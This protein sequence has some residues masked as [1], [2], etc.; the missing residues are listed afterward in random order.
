[1]N[2]DL[3]VLDLRRLVFRPQQLSEIGAIAEDLAP[4]IIPTLD[5]TLG[6]WFGESDAGAASDVTTYAS[7]PGDLSST[8]ES[9]P[10]SDVMANPEP[11]PVLQDLQ[12]VSAPDLSGAYVP[13]VAI[14][15]PSNFSPA[16]T[17]SPTLEAIEPT[18]S[19]I[20]T[21]SIPTVEEQLSTLKVSDTI[22][23]PQM[24]YST[25]GCGV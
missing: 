11:T 19:E 12:S 18:L 24:G 1:M 23:E 7:T 2:G 21:L 15:T 8:M 17:Y 25:I 20:P 16:L 4:E 13:T 14:D 5:S 9:V 3:F 22:S 6:S 10:T